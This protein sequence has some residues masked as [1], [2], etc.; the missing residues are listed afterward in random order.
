MIEWWFS[1]RFYTLSAGK[2]SNSTKHTFYHVVTRIV[3]I[4]SHH[5]TEFLAPTDLRGTD[6]PATTSCVLL[7][8]LLLLLLLPPSPPPPAVR[9]TRLIVGG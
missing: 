1:T 4:T 6:E 7:L 8:L 9:V 5:Q 2:R 3:H